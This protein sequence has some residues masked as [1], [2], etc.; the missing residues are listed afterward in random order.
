MEY[1]VCKDEKKREE[2]KGGDK[3]IFMLN[4]IA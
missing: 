4:Q 1:L 2:E 3:K